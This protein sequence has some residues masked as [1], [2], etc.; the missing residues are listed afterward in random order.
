MKKTR[1][2]TY[3]GAGSG[4]GGRFPGKARRRVVRRPCLIVVTCLFLLGAPPWADAQD[5]DNVEYPVKLAFLYNFAKF[6][7]WPQ[8]AFRDGSAPFVICV[9]GQDP[10]AAEMEQAA[11]NR[12]V[13]GRLIAIQKLTPRDNL[14]GCH[15]VFLPAAAMKHSDRIVAGLKGASV[16]TVGETGGFA[17]RGG[18][19]NLI[20]VENKLRFEINPDAAREARLRVSSKLLALGR[21]VKDQ[22]DP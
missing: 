17:A 18:I 15:M 9:V 12:S 4:L 10:F 7:Q 5:K 16:L 1:W 19:I 21:I 2:Q 13:G 14:S 3:D 20:V 8:D 6:V 22:P 11:R